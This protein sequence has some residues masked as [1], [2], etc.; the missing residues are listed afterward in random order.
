LL[1]AL[2]VLA[3]ALWASFGDLSLS[4]GLASARKALRERRANEAVSLL[5]RH[6]DCGAASAEWRFL[7]A[8]AERRAGMLSE[9]KRQLA[10]AKALG[11][12]A[13]DVRREELLLGALSGRIK[14]VEPELVELLAAGAGDEAA[15][16]IYEAM[17]QGY[18]TAYYASDALRCLEFWSAWQPENLVPRLW[19]AELHERTARP[20]KAIAAYRQVLELDPSRRDAQA[21]LGELLLKKLELDEA[22]EIFTRCLADSADEPGA[23][24]GLAECR[25]RQGSDD[26]ARELL[27][28]ALTLELSGDQAA[29]ATGMLGALALEERDYARAVGL[30]EKSVLLDA[31]EPDSHASLAAAL[32]ALGQ[33]ELAAAERQK[34]RQAS[35]L[36]TRYV[37]TTMKVLNDP[38]NADLRCEAGLIL[39]EQGSWS[40]AA[41]W[42]ESALAIDPEHRGAQDALAKLHKMSGSD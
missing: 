3:A 16:D 42:L 33:E 14:E 24:L 26:Q 13:K 18:W 8:R 41:E 36:R 25:R 4:Y 39:L 2:A 32:A 21:K 31:T 6:A 22:G 40:E 10:R 12:G 29:R 7:L 1:C 38:A 30:L 19:I 35:D 11:C 28:D 9:A 23:L 34:A 27:Y 15:E 17:A 5:K 20:D 37:R